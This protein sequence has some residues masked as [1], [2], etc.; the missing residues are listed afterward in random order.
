MPSPAILTGLAVGA[1]LGFILQRGR[2]CITGAFRDLWVSRSWRWFTAFLL[3]IAVQAV[4]VAILTGAGSI[5]PEI[6]RLSVVATVVGSFLF[7]VGIVLAGGCATGTYYRAGEGLVGSWFALVAYATT[8]AASKTGILSGVTTWVKGLWVTD[9]TTIPATIG[10]PDWVGVVILAGATAVVV[11]R[12]VVLG[13]SR[14]AQVQL[15][16][17][18]TGLAHLLLEKQWNPLFTGLL[19]GVVAIIAW[20]A[21]WASGRLDGLGITTP[22]SNLVGLIVTGDTKRLDWGVLLVLGI[23][24][25]SYIA[26]K[27]SGEFRVRVPSAQ[28]IQRSIIGGVLM[29]VGAAWAGGCSIGNALVQTSLLS[30]QGWIALVFQVLGVGAAAWFILIRPRQ[31][32][33]AQRADTPVPP[34]GGPRTNPKE[35][36]MRTVLETTGQVCPFPVIEAEEAMEELNV[37]DELVIGFDCTQGTQTLP[38]WAADNG[39]T[40]TEFERTGDA[41]W[42]ITVRK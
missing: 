24:L 40:V 3:A 30:W 8:A 2:F 22:S 7:G 38:A 16:A 31:R 14:P 42:T 18:R 12:F 19:V 10:V 34:T 21:S 35:R 15:P 1:V 37:G 25:G 36:I 28:V 33:R 32:R 5:T 20:P 27:A 13:R 4:G 23:L 41:A 6:P 17:Q 9:L 26:A 11:H 29:G 39:Y